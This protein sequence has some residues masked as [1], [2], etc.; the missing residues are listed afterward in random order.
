MPESLSVGTEE[1]R[2][3]TVDRDRSISFMGEACRVYA[4]PALVHDI[5][6]ACRDLIVARLPEGQDSVGYRIEVTHMAPT[7]LGMAVT[8]TVRIAEFDGRRV[9]L[10]IE[11]ADTVEPVARGRHERFVVDVEKTA[12]RL[13]AK[14]AQAGEAAG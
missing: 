3:I 9:V 2:E 1:R 10:E 7:P 8:I 11:A 14:A 12:Q 5:E 6:H 13:Q 4:T